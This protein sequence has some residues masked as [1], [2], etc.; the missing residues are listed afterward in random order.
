VAPHV[1]YQLNVYAEWLGKAGQE[2]FP[3]LADEAA[4]D[5]SGILNVVTPDEAVRMIESYVAEVPLERYYTWTVPPG[6][7]AKAMNEH[8]E[9]FANKVIPHFR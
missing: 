5:A 2:L 6:F 7:P 8:L 9:L 4:L 1:L 3:H